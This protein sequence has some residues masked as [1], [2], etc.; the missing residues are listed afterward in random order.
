[1]HPGGMLLEEEHLRQV[2]VPD[3]FERLFVDGHALVISPFQQ[4]AGRMRELQRRERAHGSCGIGFG[5]AVQDSLAARTDVIRV[6]D[7]TDTDRLAC[8]LTSQRNRKLA[9]F[10]HLDERL[11]PMVDRELTLLRDDA[12]IDRTLNA[13]SQ[14]TPR[15]QILRSDESV[16]RIK[17]SKVV[18]F[19]GSQ[20]VLLDQDLGFHPH[21]TWSDCTVGE[22]DKLLA[23]IHCDVYRLGILRSYMVRHGAGPFPTFVPGFN[24]KQP[25]DHNG[26]SGWQGE[27][28][29]GPLDMVLLRYALRACGGA[30]GLAVTCLD[31]LPDSVPVCIAHEFAGMRR[32]ELSVP[33]PGDHRALQ[34]LGAELRH[35]RPVLQSVPRERLIAVIEKE[36]RTPIALTSDGPTATDRHWIKPPTIPSRAFPG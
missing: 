3:A 4:A 5:E 2:G 36:L 21:T 10:G 7:L 32:E 25:E 11:V 28:R 29:R 1:M 24:M 9:E 16:Q 14:L 8:R 17:R 26:D 23:G 33:T 12:S 35:S 18:V 34:Q 15:L 22:A 6:R 30:D 19:E 27:F 20:G 13:W 31:Q